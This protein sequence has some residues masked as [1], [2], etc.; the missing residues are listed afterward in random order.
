MKIAILK[1]TGNLNSLVNAIADLSLK[2]F[3]VEVS[4]NLA[5]YARLIIPGVGNI[6]SYS[7]SLSD[8][9]TP[10]RLARYV[11]NPA[12]RLLGIC[13]GFQY[14][15]NFSEE[16]PSAQCCKLLPLSFSKFKTDSLKRVPHVG[17]NELR[18]SSNISKN[19]D[20]YFTHSYAAMRRPN[21]ASLGVFSEY[22][23]TDYQEKFISYCRLRNVYGI[24]SHPEKSR[25]EG[26]DF[27]NKF[28]TE[29]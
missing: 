12:N 29:D 15:S 17:W 28:I 19:H 9:D 21:E 11:E 18:F 22:A 4:E 20:Q 27:L 23:L 2:P 10:H 24:Q 5:E 1:T 26:L 8:F 16:E 13:V 25:Q 3:I 14:L 7:R 6:G